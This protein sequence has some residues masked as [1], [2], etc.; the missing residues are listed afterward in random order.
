MPTKEERLAELKAQMDEIENEPD[1]NA[2]SRSTITN[3]TIDLSDPAQV[4]RGIAMGLLDKGDL[5]EFDE[6]PAETDP[7]AEPEDAPQRKRERYD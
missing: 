5:D 7:E 4:K 2:P 6:A 1:P 3:V